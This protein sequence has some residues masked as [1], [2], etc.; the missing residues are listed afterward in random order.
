[1]K[2]LIYQF[3]LNCFPKLVILQ[4]HASS[5]F[6]GCQKS[7]HSLS[8]ECFD[9]FFNQRHNNIPKIRRSFKI[10][11]SYEVE[12]VHD[13]LRCHFVMAPLCVDV[14]NVACIF[15]SHQLEI[16]L[17]VISRHHLVPV[18]V[19]PLVQHSHWQDYK[20]LRHSKTSIGK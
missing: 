2:L 16:D 9:L 8:V 19:T 6:Y 7:L 12:A 14:D 10:V 13:L 5:A 4:I 15:G 1:M 20:C 3:L 17:V 18:V 11:L